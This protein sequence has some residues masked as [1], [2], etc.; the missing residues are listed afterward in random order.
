MS[1]K[2]Y[3]LAD[4]MIGFL[5][6]GFAGLQVGLF[7]DLLLQPL[8]FYGDLVLIGSLLCGVASVFYGRRLTDFLGDLWD[9]LWRDN[10]DL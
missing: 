1:E 3:R 9:Q 2:D 7:T 8:L 4:I 5:V 10:P 6:G